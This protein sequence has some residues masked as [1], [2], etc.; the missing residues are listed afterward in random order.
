MKRISFLFLIFSGFQLVTFGQVNPNN[1]VVKGYSKSNGTYVP[2]YHATDQN[3]TINDNYTTIP[4]VNPY[5]GKEGTIQPLYNSSPIYK[6]PVYKEPSY[7]MPVYKEPV[8]KE[9]SFKM[10]VYKEPVYRA[11]RTSTRMRY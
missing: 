8:Y 6:E 7:R 11:P 2:P 4:N 9:P 10:P 1:H 5:T 3:K